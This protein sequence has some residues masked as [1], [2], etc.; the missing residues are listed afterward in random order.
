MYTQVDTIKASVGLNA[1][2]YIMQSFFNAVLYGF[3][4]EVFPAPIRGS[5][6]GLCSTFGRL[7]GIVAPIAAR[8]YIDGN[9]NGVL[10]LAV[11]G[12]FVSAFFLI[13]LPIETRGRASY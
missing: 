13:F 6:A 10:W 4:P 5:A 11:G 8:P 9:S 1:L 7:A 12:I 3:T 2:E